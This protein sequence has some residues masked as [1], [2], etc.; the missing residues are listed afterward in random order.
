M[1]TV[2]AAEALLSHR[3][4]FDASELTPFLARSLAFAREAVHFE[5]ALPAVSVRRGAVCRC[6]PPCALNRVRR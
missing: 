3:S 4:L 2:R 6:A 5:V 1:S